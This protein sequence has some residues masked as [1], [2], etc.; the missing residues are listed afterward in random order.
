MYYNGIGVAK[1]QTKVF[2]LTQKSCDGGVMLACSNLAATYYLGV[3]IAKDEPKA[4]ALDRQ[5]CDGGEPR[6]C[7]GAAVIDFMDH[8]GFDSAKNY[9]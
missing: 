9:E 8:E 2:Q 5:A 4:M 1:D 6:G 7:A 3:G